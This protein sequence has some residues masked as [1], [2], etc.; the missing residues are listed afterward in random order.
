MNPDGSEQRV[1]LGV[2][3]RPRRPGRVRADAVGDR[4]P[5]TP[6]TTPAAP[7]A[8]AAESYRDH[9]NTPASIEVDALGRTVTAVARNGADPDTD[10]FVTRSTYDIQ[11]NLSR[12]PT[13]S[14]ARRFRYR[15]DLPSAAGGWTASTP[16]AATPSWTPLG[17]PSRGPGQQGRAHPGAFDALHRPIRVWARDDAAGPVTLRQR[18]DYGDGGDPDQPAA[19][20][21]AARAQNLLGRPVAHYDEAGLVTVDRRRLQGQRA[22][23]RPP[24]D[25]R[26]PDP[27]H[28]RPA[29]PPTAGR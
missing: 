24:G 14:A 6:T 25:R 26:R 3:D 7:T 17:A 28:L 15:Y 2:P 13:R 21:A 29:P 22:R 10:W 12:S 11:G 23:D 16:A 1:V 18:I 9:W 20:R 27:R 19:D 8:A 5:T 4:S